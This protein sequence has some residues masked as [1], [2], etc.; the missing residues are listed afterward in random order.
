MDYL[1]ENTP[2]KFELKISRSYEEAVKD[3]R[4]GKTQIS[5]LGDGAFA[6]AALLNVAVPIVKPLNREGKPFY[7]CAIIVPRNSSLRSV[8]DLRGRRMALG[9][10]HSTTGNL[11]P[12]HMLSAD[13]I[14]FHSL[15]SVT[16]LKNHDAVTKAILKGQYDAGAV[17]D[18]FAEKFKEHGLRVLAYSD[19][20]PSVPLTV[21]RKVSRN[22]VETVTAALLK[23]DPN[24]PQHRK[25][26]ENWDEE[27][28]YGF[29]PANA[30]DYQ[31]I[32]WMFKSIP[33]GCGTRCHK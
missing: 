7:R 31:S 18:V 1:T 14:A 10:R 19:P 9:S 28:K 6:E 32:F 30:S 13:G 27:L 11:I 23:L 29:V 24:N 12:R 2:Y 25:L 4:E 21:G 16:N 5:S 15:G 33:Y 20:V 3:L 17:K 22:F 26:M 8:R